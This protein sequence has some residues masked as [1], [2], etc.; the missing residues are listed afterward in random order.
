LA[1]L[2]HREQHA[3]F[4]RVGLGGLPLGARLL[5]PPHSPVIEQA[6]QEGGLLHGGEV[7]QQHPALDGELGV[8]VLQHGLAAS[9]R[10]EHNGALSTWW[11]WSWLDSK[12]RK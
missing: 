12:L 5:R 10:A 4:E 9:E 7:V 1:A 6:Q 8:V 11:S 2:T 3:P